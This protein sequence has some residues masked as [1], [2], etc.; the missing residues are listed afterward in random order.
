MSLAS[1]LDITHEVWTSSSRLE[2]NELQSYFK[3]RMHKLY[4]AIKWLTE[5]HEDYKDVNIDHKL[6]TWGNEVIAIALLNSIS[7]VSD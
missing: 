2:R 3:V 4:D 7:T 5:Y 6:T 1:L